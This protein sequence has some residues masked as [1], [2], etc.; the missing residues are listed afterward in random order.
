MTKTGMK[1]IKISL[2]IF[3]LVLTTTVFCFWK[4]SLA[5]ENHLIINELL[6]NPNESSE[7][8]AEF[9]ELYNPTSAVI[10]LTDYYF[11]G[12]TEKATEEKKFPLSGIIETKEYKAFYDTITLYNEKNTIKL[13]RFKVK[14]VFDS[15]DDVIDTITY[16]DPSTKENYSYSLILN[17]NDWLWTSPTTPDKENGDHENDE[18]NNPNEEKNIY[19]GKIKINEILP[20]PKTKN[21]GKEFVEIINISD[22]P[23]NLSGM[24]I[25]DEKKHKVAFPE[26]LLAPQEFFVLEGNFELNNTSPDSA[27]LVAKDTTKENPLDTVSYGKPKYDY[28]Y[29]FDGV[30]WQ[31]TSK[32]TKG[33]KNQFDEL[34]AGKIKKDKKIYANVYANFE[35][36]TDNKAHKFTWNFGDGHKSYLKKTRHKYEKSGVYNA[37]LKITGAGKENLLNFTVK[38]IKFK[39]TKLQIIALVPNPA[40]YDSKN[41]WLEIFNGTK[42]KINLKNWSVATGWKNLYN[43]PI[44]KNFILKAGETKKLT[45]NFSA[46]TLGNKQARIELRYPDGK[47]ADK[48]KYDR[49]NDSI[50][51]EELYQKEGKDWNWILPQKNTE[52]EPPNIKIDLKETAQNP[53]QVNPQNETE[54]L[55]DLTLS[56]LGEYTKNP[57]WQEK[58]EKQIT[59]LFVGSNISPT[60]LLSQN[61]GQVLG[62][63]SIKISHE[64][65]PRLKSFDQFWKK[66][67]TQLNKLFLLTQNKTS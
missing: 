55:K 26:K 10:D 14:N 22:K 21:A 51:E 16:P 47:V 66:I 17:S 4:N 57:A 5:E 46:F 28:A 33:E 54:K 62:I 12:K 48:I 41:E 65:I 61:Q 34:L 40:G 27:I 7:K 35:V 1:N 32:I 11:S 8:K 38:V 45:H 15:A 58:Q 52:T 49:K 3:I 2:I 30:V 59:L 39:K 24:H 18:D 23:I 63:S 64:E 31:W 37:T 9:I 36:I 19:A 43:H 13:L 60:K 50:L 44:T 6:P 29:A 25:E 42:K 56:T 20:A 53:P 67:N